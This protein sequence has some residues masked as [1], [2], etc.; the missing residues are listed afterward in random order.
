MIW[1]ITECFAPT[2]LISCLIPDVEMKYIVSVYSVICAF[3]RC[4]SLFPVAE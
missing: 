2:V 4:E 1:L 3:S